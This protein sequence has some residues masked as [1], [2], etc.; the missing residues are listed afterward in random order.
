MTENVRFPRRP[1]DETMKA[2]TTRSGSLIHYTAGAVIERNGRYLLIERAKPP[3]ELSCVAGHIHEAEEPH[4]AVIREVHEEVG[5]VV[6]EPQL[7]FDE[8]IDWNWC[9]Y[10]VTTHHWYVFGCP[11]QGFLQPSV[12]EVK[13]AHWFTSEEIALLKL[14]D[15]WEYILRKIAIL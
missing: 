9:R 14:E 4:T 6:T 2:T 7:L 8:V 12:E 11:T 3:Y 13:C 5:L 15:V 10:G 1:L